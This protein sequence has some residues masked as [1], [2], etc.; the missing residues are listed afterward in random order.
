M[1]TQAQLTD[2]YYKKLYPELEILEK[3]RKQ[4]L[5]QLFTLGLIYSIIIFLSIFLMYK[6]FFN[7]NIIILGGF[8]YLFGGGLLYKYLIKDYTAAFKHNIIAPLITA[9]DKNLNYSMSSHISKYLFTSSKIFTTYPDKF[10]GNDYIEGKI[11]DVKIEFSDILAQKKHQNSKGKTHYETLFQGPFIVA[12]FHKHFKG[13]T[14]VVPDTAQKTFGNLIGQWLQSYNNSH[15]QLVKMDDVDFEKKFVVYSSDQIEARYILSN[16]LMQRL[17]NFQKRSQY[18]ISLSFVEGKMFLA[19][20][21]NKDLFEPSIFHSLLKYKIAIEYVATL[22]LAISIVEE[23]K[24]NQKLW[25]K[26]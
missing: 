24:L 10:E 26:L 13:A 17:L 14:I 19:I 22:H 3:R 25:S 16:T 2:F 1:K 23:L 15:G 5:S 7:T 9:L 18:P 21:Y 4:L 6:I 12:D 20:H 11:D 8:V